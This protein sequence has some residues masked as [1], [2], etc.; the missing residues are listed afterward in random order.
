MKMD[1]QMKKSF[2][3]IIIMGYALITIS[4][5]FLMNVLKMVVY[6]EKQKKVISWGQIKN[7][8]SQEEK[9]NL[10]SKKLKYFKLDLGKCM[11]N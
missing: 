9:K 10:M 3:A 5:K 8:N 2:I 1:L 11:K 4:L 6:A 7:M